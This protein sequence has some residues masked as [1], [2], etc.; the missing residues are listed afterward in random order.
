MAFSKEELK[1]IKQGLPRGAAKE[2]AQS[3]GLAYVTVNKIL[4]GHFNNDEVILA[5][6]DKY[7]AHQLKIDQAKKRLSGEPEQLSVA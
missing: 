3:L 5:A 4:N 2:I 6:F 1:K 7:E